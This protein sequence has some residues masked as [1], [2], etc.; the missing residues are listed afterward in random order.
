[1]LSGKHNSSF[2]P[3]LASCRDGNTWH[4]QGEKRMPWLG[5]SST[6]KWLVLVPPKRHLTG[7]SEWDSMERKGW[8]PQPLP[9]PGATLALPFV[10]C[11]SKPRGSLS[12]NIC[13]SRCSTWLRGF[14]LSCSFYEI[15]IVPVR[16]H[17][18]THFFLYNNTDGQR[19]TKSQQLACRREW[20]WEWECRMDGV[21]M[22]AEN[23]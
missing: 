7:L 3:S 9:K 2:P 20:E 12:P 8:Y 4:S 16:P 23:A 5:E 15:H 22:S 14:A 18:S 19:G 10:P 1:M 11:T 6:P 13:L 21:G 17:F